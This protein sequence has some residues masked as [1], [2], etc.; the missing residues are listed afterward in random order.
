MS[1]NNINCKRLLFI[2]KYSNVGMFC[3]YHRFKLTI[4]GIY[5]TLNEI[6]NK[7][8]ELTNQSINGIFQLNKLKNTSQET[9]VRKIINASE[10]TNL[11]IISFKSIHFCQ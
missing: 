7:T 11:K 5:L 3:I 1:C 8:K 9:I 4:E 10:V 6:Q 2:M